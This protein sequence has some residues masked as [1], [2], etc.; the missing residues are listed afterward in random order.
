M[1]A[2]AS[3]PSRGFAACLMAAVACCTGG[4]TEALSRLYPVQDLHFHFAPLG[5]SARPMGPAGDAVNECLD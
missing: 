3:S 4:Q 5:E 2:V 1:L